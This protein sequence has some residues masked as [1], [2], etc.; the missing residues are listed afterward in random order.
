LQICHALEAAHAKNV[1]HRDLKPGNILVTPAG[2][3]LLDFGLAN[4]ALAA[5]D[6][7]AAETM[8][9]RGSRR[10]YRLQLREA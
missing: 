5:A 7:D 4:V 6:A 10:D 8:G 3:K 2:V 1:I 9:A